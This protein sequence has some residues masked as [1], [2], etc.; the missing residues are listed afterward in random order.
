MEIK[1]INKIRPYTNMKSKVL[2][3]L[4]TV[5]IIT[6][7]THPSAYWHNKKIF[8]PINELNLGGL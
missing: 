1:N 3:Q 7:K 2:K 6:V 4:K 5:I 8:K